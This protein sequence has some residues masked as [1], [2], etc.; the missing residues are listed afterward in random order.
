[1]ITKKELLFIVDGKGIDKKAYQYEAKGHD[2]EAIAE[3]IAVCNG[4]LNHEIYFDEEAKEI[5]K[6]EGIYQNESGIWH[7][8]YNSIIE[9][10]L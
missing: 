7:N 9:D 6:S 1:M 3:H 8:K 4:W 10:L 5:A 2:Y